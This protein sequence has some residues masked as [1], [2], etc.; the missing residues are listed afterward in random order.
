[1]GRPKGFAAR[2]RMSVM[3]YAPAEQMQG[4]SHRCAGIMSKE[5]RMQV[6]L[7][8]YVIATSVDQQARASQMSVQ[9]SQ[10]RTQHQ[11]AK[12]V[13]TNR[14]AKAGSQ[15]AGAVK[16][17]QVR[18]ALVC[19]HRDLHR[20]RAA[21]S[22]TVRRHQCPV[23]TKVNTGTHRTRCRKKHLVNQLVHQRQLDQ[24]LP[25]SKL[26]MT[27]R[28]NIVSSRHSRRRSAAGRTARPG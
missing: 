11:T 10:T 27:T 7:A 8:R 4:K 5:F 28:G 19:R 20:D 22:G 12:A 24:G 15:A 3:E 2:A 25:R 21:A 26:M 16:G 23:D 6:V 13:L 1:M 14:A 18:E 17:R 9:V